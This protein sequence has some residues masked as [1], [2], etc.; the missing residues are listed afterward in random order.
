MSD[1]FK[2]VLQPRDGLDRP[3]Q[4]DLEEAIRAAGWSDDPGT[5][6]AVLL[7]DGSEM[8][9]PLPIAPPVDFVTG[10]TLLEQFEAKMEARFRMLQEDAEVD[11]LEDFE[12]F[13]VEEDVE[14][15]PEPGIAE[16]K[17]IFG[18]VSS[19]TLVNKLF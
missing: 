10:P 3:S 7:P 1:K 15:C 12:D 17:L 14:P 4:L 13:D 19:S 18:S 2:V 11:T 5:G 6:K 16:L 8:L 9:N